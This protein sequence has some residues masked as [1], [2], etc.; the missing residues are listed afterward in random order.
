[1]SQNIEIQGAESTSEWVKWIDDA[2]DQE[3]FKYY[4]YIKL[5]LLIQ[6][7]INIISFYGITKFEPDLAIKQ[8]IIWQA[9]LDKSVPHFAAGAAGTAGVAAGVTAAVVFGNRLFLEIGFL[10]FL[11]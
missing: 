8:I 10:S 2:I 7:H 9:V 5:Q 3:Y 6:F 11:V 1:M 4:E